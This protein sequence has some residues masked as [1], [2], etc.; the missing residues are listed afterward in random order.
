MAVAAPVVEPRPGAMPP[1]VAPAV[2]PAAGAAP[3]EGDAPALAA[4][5]IQIPAIQG[6][7]SGAPSATSVPIQG[8]DKLPEG[9]AII[10][11]KDSLMNAGFGFYTSLA[12]D[13][14]A[15]FNRAY[16]SDNEIMDADKAGKL[17]E[18]APPLDQVNLQLS[19][20]GQQNPILNAQAPPGMKTGG[21]A[22]P[23]AAASSMPPMPQAAGSKTPARTVQAKLRNLD[24]GGP[25]DGAKPG[26]G[27]L[28]NQILK[29][30]V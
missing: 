18:I 25:T 19:Q 14:G 13:T 9:Q 2:E 23:T 29:P 7:L 22:S 17:L 20:S 21:A 11:N 1:P 5:L 3:V 28:M 27:R 10:K 15:I 26:A 8:F 16:V 12:G 24:V 4:E 6:M 30:V